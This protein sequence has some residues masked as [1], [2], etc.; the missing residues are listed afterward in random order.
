MRGGRLEVS[1]SA[2]GSTGDARISQ[3]P[4]CTKPQPEKYCVLADLLIPG[5]GDPIEHGC[6]IVEDSKIA[7]AGKATDMQSQNANLPKTRVKVLMPGMWDCHVH[8]MGLQRI[9]DG[10]FLEAAHSQALTGARIARDVMLLLNAG[11]TSVR[12]MAGYGLQIGQGIK[13]GSIVGPNIYSSKK[14]IVSL[15]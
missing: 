10:A 6:V 15:C 11:F 3:A 13:E 8:L 7:F 5:K 12:E 9:D 14:I 1:H 4:T 2:I